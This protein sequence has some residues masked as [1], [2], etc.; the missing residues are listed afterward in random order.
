VPLEEHDPTSARAAAG[1][2]SRKDAPAIERQI[3]TQQLP[4][5]RDGATIG[6]RIGNEQKH[7]RDGR[8]VAPL[9]CDPTPH[10][11]T[12]ANPGL[13]F[14]SVALAGQVKDAV[15]R[16]R[17]RPAVQRNLAVNETAGCSRTRSLSS[18]RLWGASRSGSPSGY[19]RT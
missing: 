11:L 19:A 8:I 7:V 9:Q 18:R 13:R 5:L 6:R 3:R 1:A 16:P 14:D 2:E 10:R 4:N 15:P 17:I 12:V